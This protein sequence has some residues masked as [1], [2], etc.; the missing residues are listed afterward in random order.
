LFI[1]LLLLTVFWLL[2]VE[3]RLWIV[4][5]SKLL[6]DLNKTGQH[7]SPVIEHIIEFESIID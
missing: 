1:V 7:V 5:V 2:M 6:S 4:T 3:N